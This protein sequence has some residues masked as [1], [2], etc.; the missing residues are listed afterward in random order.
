METSEDS[1]SFVE[2]VVGQPFLL[3]GQDL[4][5]VTQTILQRSPGSFDNSD[6]YM[7]DRCGRDLVGQSCWIY[8]RCWKHE[9]SHCKPYL[10]QVAHPLSLS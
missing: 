5:E 2:A 7:P 4:K 9:F 3:V 10:Q 6:H 8:G 1:K